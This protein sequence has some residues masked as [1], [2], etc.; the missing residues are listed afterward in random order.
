MGFNGHPRELEEVLLTH[1]QVSL[2]ALVGVPQDSHGE[3]VKPSS[4]G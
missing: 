1:P 2:A 3:E 4:V